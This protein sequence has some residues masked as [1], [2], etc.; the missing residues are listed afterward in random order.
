MAEEQRK[1]RLILSIETKGAS[2]AAAG[3]KQLDTSVTDLQKELGKIA[4]TEQ[5]QKVAI[6]MGTLARKTRDVGGAVA[7]LDKKLKSLGANQDEIQGLAGT[8][9]AAA[10]GQ[11]GGNRLSRLGS[12]LR[13]LPSQQ[14]PG[15]GIGTDAIANF[16]RLG[17]AI[18]GVS[19]KTAQATRLGAALTPVLGATGAGFVSMTVAAA[20]FVLALGAMALAVK[21]FAD[22]TSQQADAI[23]KYA[24]AQRSLNQ[25]I[26]NGLTTEEAQEKL[27]K[28]QESRQ[29]EQ[30]TL[31]ELQ[32]A[33]SE[34]EQQ[35]SQFGIASGLAGAATRALSGDEEALASQ[36][37]TSTNNVK[38][39][40]EEIAFL[41][42]ALE[43]GTLAANDAKL[44][45]EALAKER[46]KNALADADTA[47]KELQAQQKA[48]NS[49]AAQNEKRLESIEDE[50][51][52][53]EKQIEVLTASGVTS[54]EVTAKL[55]SLNAQLGLLGKESE[56]INETALEQ[57]RARD[58]QIEAEKQAKESAE[59]AARAQEQYDKAIKS[60]ATTY[61]NAVQDIGTRLGQTLADNTLK[62]NR[63]L[64]DIATKFR[65]DEYDLTIK[66]NRAERDAQ[67]AQID[68]IADIREEAS[69]E[70][71]EALREGDFKALFLARQKNAETLQQ[72]QVT[73][74]KARI[75][76]QQDA[77]DARA[78]LLRA[79]ERTRADRM[80]AYDRQNMDARTAQ[81]RD[82]Q[83]AQLTRQRSLQLARESYNAEL[84]QLG[85]Y[86]Q[87]RLRMEQQ[88]YQQSLGMVS[89]GNAPA[90]TTNPYAGMTAV[91]RVIKK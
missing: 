30:G 50:K 32:G 69:K 60:A 9:N 59:K 63:D 7:E 4:R 82:L 71:Q 17:G 20:P 19:E 10:S 41:T 56:F 57:S 44:A 38:K 52:V 48:L 1:A 81:Q 12:E 21:G 45:E 88:Y 5:L 25:D 27:R 55:A 77:S 22:V 28:L 24:E 36:I 11:I 6:E 31:D 53:I 65:R 67:Q 49:T 29:L 72:E 68:D 84:Q 78:D 14:I 15:L 26:V 34:Y 89:G 35:L 47:A 33:Y 83:Q 74:D 58:A 13:A 3:I 39:Y 91:A 18:S 51:D 70:E 90:A 16:I 37:G 85:G 75:Q 73:L 8:F 79:S 76:R 62:F 87:A 42:S 23:N 54:E 40:D 66:A 43:D 64:T 86:L 61:K 46:S 2:E 80:L